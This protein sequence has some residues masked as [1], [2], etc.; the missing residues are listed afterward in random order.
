ML[1][2]LQWYPSCDDLKYIYKWCQIC[3]H[4]DLRG[5]ED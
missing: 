3:H 5:G 4:T 1:S 2:I